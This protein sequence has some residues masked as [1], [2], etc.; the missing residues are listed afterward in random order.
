[1][2]KSIVLILF[3]TLTFG[4]CAPK[5][6]ERQF[7]PA[8]ETFGPAS[9]DTNLNLKLREYGQAPPALQWQGHVSSSQFLQTSEAIV[10]L[11]DLL[12][13]DRLRNVGLNW[14]EKF[15]NT[16]GT[17]WSQEVAQ[18][19]FTGLA[20]SQTQQQVRS[21]LKDA[22]E[23]IEKARPLIRA[24]IL[25]LPTERSQIPTEDLRG[26]LETARAFSQSVL[27]EVP[28][29]GLA[30]VIEDGLQKELVAT[31]EPLF[32]DAERLLSELY[33]S[34]TL[35]QILAL[36]ENTLA[37]FEIKLDDKLLS[38]LKQ[39]HNIARGL[40]RMQDAQ[41]A[42]TVII[43]VWRMLTPEEQSQHF[44]T[45]NEELYDFLVRQ[46]AKEL[47]CLRTEGCSGGLIDGI[48]KKLFILPKIKKYGVEKLKAEMNKSTYEYVMSEILKFA[49]EFVKTMPQTF[50]DS[51]DEGIADKAIRVQHVYD[52]YDEYVISL[53]KTWQQKVLPDRKGRL[54]GFEVPQ[55][56]I[57]IR[58]GRDV[59]ISPWVI[60]P[61]VRGEVIGSGLAAEALLIERRPE[62]GGAFAHMLGQINK[63]VAISGYRK[64]NND[65]TPALLAPVNHKD[66]LLDILNFDESKNPELSFRIP[67]MIPLKDAFHA[68]PAMS[69]EK[70][71]SARNFASQIRGL[72]RSLRLT[73]DWKHSAMNDLLGHIQAQDLTQDAQHEDLRQALFPKDM[74]FALNL[75]NI[76][77]L[78]QDITKKATPVF[79]LSVDKN[80]VWADSYGNNQ[81]T[82]VM[83]GIVDVQNSQ[84]SDNLKSSAN[85]HFL[86]AIN[87]FLEATEGVENTKSPVLLEKDS[88]G[89]TPL[90]TLQEGRKDLRLLSLAVANF[91]SYQ[92]IDR[93]KLVVSE[94]SLK[95]MTARKG[96]FKV[97]D[98]VLA[99]RALLKAWELTKIDSYLWSAQEIYF[100]MNRLLFHSKD[101]FYRNSDGTA[102]SWAERVEVLLALHTL[103][104]HLPPESQTQLD[105]LTSPWIEA[106]KTFR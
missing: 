25:Q 64:M 17:T 75:G 101:E 105:R 78:L 26:I 8:K 31:T 47:E 62:S 1:M 46:D 61:G 102:I 41:S 13:S 68:D 3:T 56:N 49:S 67:D 14:I 71:F 69:Y 21:T 2:K 16:E 95:S 38:S 12:S 96:T 22:L 80:I 53:F 33:S 39:G 57:D 29:M 100:A 103:K 76:A 74:L 89:E 63:L 82:S 10:Q 52:S 88:T 20:T 77:I 91:I 4:A 11:G 45:A 73:A 24:R 5:V 98:Q 97:V 90:Q 72:S 43:D 28:R 55:L 50:A 9:R 79:L 94:W 40:D 36:I 7:Q 106:L 99:I 85:S 32:A 70:N 44:K 84:R 34:H 83:V 54:M 42:L 58:S 30:P 93:T 6:E 27:E 65:L 19:P 35:S 104:P 81:E 60:D 86:L 48:T 51:I 92:L 15:Y 87:E 18:S 37:Q 23:N 59:K 66:K